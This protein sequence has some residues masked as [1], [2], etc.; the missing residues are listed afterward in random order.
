MLWA[1][2]QTQPPREAAMLP[3]LLAAWGPIAAGLQSP[4]QAAA[5]GAAACGG[6]PPCRGVLTF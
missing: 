4:L 2:E 1:L 6:T 3:A 5:Q